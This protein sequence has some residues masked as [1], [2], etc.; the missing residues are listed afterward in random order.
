MS[1]IKGVPFYIIANV[2]HSESA[3][4]D[5]YMEGTGHYEGLTEPCT[6]FFD[7]RGDDCAA[8]ICAHCLPPAGPEE[9][10]LHVDAN[11]VGYLI[12]VETGETKRIGTWRRVSPLIAHLVKGWTYVGGSYYV[13]D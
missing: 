4:P 10:I 12:D 9:S 11:R 1:K 5:S 2:P 8:R 13:V 6:L 3:D 7:L